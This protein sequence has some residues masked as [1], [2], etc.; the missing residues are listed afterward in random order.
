M[1]TIPKVLLMVAAL[2]LY[3]FARGRYEVNLHS[4]RDRY[5]RIGLVVS[6]LRVFFSAVDM[7]S[8]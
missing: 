5:V 4:T 7:Y 1:D 8:S 2:V 3:V 6:V